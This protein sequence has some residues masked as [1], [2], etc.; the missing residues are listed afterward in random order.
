MK[1]EL[2]DDKSLTGGDPR[3]LE[4]RAILEDP[5]GQKYIGQFAKKVMTQVGSIPAKERAKIKHIIDA[6]MVDKAGNKSGITTDMFDFFRKA[7]FKEMFYN[8]FQRFSSSPE[9]AQMHADIKNAYNKAR[10]GRVVCPDDFLYIERI[11]EGGF[12]RVVHVKKKTTQSHY[13]MKIQLKTALLDTFNDDPTRIDHER[14]NVS[15]ACHRGGSS[16]TIVSNSY[17]IKVFRRFKTKNKRM[18]Q[19]GC[20]SPNNPYICTVVTPIQDGGVRKVLDPLTSE[21]PRVPVESV[22]TDFDSLIPDAPLIGHPRK[23]SHGCDRPRFCCLTIHDWC[24][25]A[26]TQEAIDTAPEGRIE[27]KRVQFYSA[28]II[29]ALV[30]LHDL[31]LMYRDLKPCNVLLM[32]DGHVKLA[33]MGGVAEFADGTCL[34]TNKEKNPFTGTEIGS[35]PQGKSSKDGPPTLNNKHRRRSI[36]GTQGYMAPEMVILPKQPRSVRVGYSNAVDYWS[37][38]VTVFKLLTGSRPFDRRRFQAFV[39]DTRCRMGLDQ[40]KYNELLDTISWPE[41][42]GSEARSVISG[43]LACKETERLGGTPDNLLAD[44]YDWFVAP[45]DEDQ[46]FFNSWDFISMHTL[47]IE[48]GI[49]SE[50]A[51]HDQSFKVRQLLGNEPEKRRRSL[52]TKRGSSSGIPSLKKE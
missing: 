7:V 8:T 6:G 12:G 35:L 16:G 46:A 51:V 49:S 28:E 45:T 52:R 20:R 41:Y 47:K 33:D 23:R 44:T 27:A 39:D 34:E 48:L 25:C 38:G 50:M 31:G 37:L 5:I 9:Y 40:K 36:M 26:S 32:G 2:S 17:F 18:I 11:G 1:K 21:P 10:I 4:M 13:A 24:Y 42:V 29:L 30:H 19:V 22:T 15:R 43:L 3:K 14:D